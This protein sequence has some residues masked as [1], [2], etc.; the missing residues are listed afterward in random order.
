M[1]DHICIGPLEN[2]KITLRIEKKNSNFY[3]NKILTQYYN[4]FFHLFI[5]QNSTNPSSK[6][7]HI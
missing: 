7:K 5:K 6:F 1:P 2:W 4:F 3:E